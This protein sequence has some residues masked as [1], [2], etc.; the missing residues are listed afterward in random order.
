MD[1]VSQTLFYPLFGR[2]Q[3]S[4]RWPELFPD[5][6]AHKAMEIAA[7]EGTTAQPMDGFPE[8]VYGLRHMILVQEARAYLETHPGAAVVNIGCGLDMLAEDLSDHE[9]TIYNLDLPDVIELR[10]RWVPKADNEIDLPYSATN[11]E[12]L[13]KVD[14]SRGVIALAGGVFFYF[15][16]ADVASLID[17]FGTAFP[18]GRMVYDAESPDATKRSERMLEKKGT[19]AEMPF[20]VKDPYSP[21]KWST[22][23]TNVT[24]EFSFL[25]RLAPKL[26]SQLPMSYRLIFL[27]LKWNKGMYF[28]RV[29][30]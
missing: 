1:N 4:D 23:V 20:K 10:H 18:G 13:S 30:F 26:R 14:A 16:V 12:W 27:M 24:V 19:P 5:P 7:Q 11:H 29:D 6:W 15:Q 9:C 28:V 22:T 2:A 17:A 3:A 8:L 21:R 25:D